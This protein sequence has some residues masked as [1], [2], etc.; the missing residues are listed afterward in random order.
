MIAGYN[1]VYRV[2]E[3][4]MTDT[5]TPKGI[6]VHF[7]VLAV[8]PFPSQKDVKSFV[9]TEDFLRLPNSD[10]FTIKEYA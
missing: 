4:Q 9:K 1:K 8:G 3:K 6:W 2:K 7:G 5:I 10:K